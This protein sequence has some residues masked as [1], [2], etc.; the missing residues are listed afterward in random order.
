MAKGQSQIAVW[1]A[2]G[3]GQSEDLLQDMDCFAGVT[4]KAAAG[5]SFR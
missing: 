5:I 2:G 3:Q 4:G 1:P